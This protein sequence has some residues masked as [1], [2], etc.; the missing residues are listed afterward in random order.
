MIEGR[1][2]DLYIWYEITLYS[3][4]VAPLVSKGTP[5]L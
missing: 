3:L 4:I 2:I 1:S 5:I